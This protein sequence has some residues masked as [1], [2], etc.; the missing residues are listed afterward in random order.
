MGADRSGGQSL[1]PDGRPGMINM[2]VRQNDQ[3]YIEPTQA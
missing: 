3:F 2:R 1:Y